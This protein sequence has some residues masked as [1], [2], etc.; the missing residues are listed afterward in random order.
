[1]IVE[2][3]EIDLIR[4]WKIFGDGENFQYLDLDVY[5]MDRETMGCRELDM[6]EWPTRYIES[7]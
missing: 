2:T 3:V 6:T 5:F 4:T 1:M 7:A